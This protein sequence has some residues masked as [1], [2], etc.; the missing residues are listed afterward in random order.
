MLSETRD[1]FLKQLANI[2]GR[3]GGAETGDQIQDLFEEANVHIR[4]FASVVHWKKLP[5]EA[6]P[7][8][9]MLLGLDSGERILLV[10]LTFE[11]NCKPK[12]T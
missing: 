6:V 9:E 5:E 2:I 4:T 7:N 3:I 8:S 12:V 1:C 10:W 11:K